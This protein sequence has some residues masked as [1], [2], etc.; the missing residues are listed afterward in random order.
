MPELDGGP[1]AVPMAFL[2]AYNG[3]VADAFFPVEVEGLDDLKG[4]PQALEFLG[5][6]LGDM[7]KTQAEVLK[8]H[9]EWRSLPEKLRNEVA[10]L[11]QQQGYD[12]LEIGTGKRQNA[13]SVKGAVAKAV[14]DRM[15]DL[16]LSTSA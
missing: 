13:L 9:P 16:E 10:L 6:L 2:E 15:L 1:Q 5:R 11:L 12:R 7:L 8:L 14:L 4:D 3:P